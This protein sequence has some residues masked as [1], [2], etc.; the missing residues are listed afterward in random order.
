M[1]RAVERGRHRPEGTDIPRPDREDTGAGH[2]DEPNVVA[3]D[4]GGDGV[5]RAWLALSPPAEPFQ[6]P[7]DLIRAS[8]SP[9]GAG[10]RWT[11]NYWA[12]HPA[13]RA[14]KAALYR[15]L[16]PDGPRDLDLPTPT[17]PAEPWRAVLLDDDMADFSRFSFTP[18]LWRGVLYTELACSR[19]GVYPAE[20]LTIGPAALRVGS[21]E[22]WVH[23]GP[24][25]Y[26]HPTRSPLSLQLR[27][28]VNRVWLWGD[29]IG[30]REARLGL[31]LALPGPDA[32]DRLRVS[33][34]IGRHD[35]GTWREAERAL[36]AFRVPRFD[37]GPEP[38]YAV[39]APGAAPCSLELSVGVAG[40]G[41]P[42]AVTEE[43]KA[44]VEVVAGARF[45][46]PLGAAV[47]E[48]HARVAGETALEVRVR[49]AGGLPLERRVPFLAGGT[50]YRD[51]PYG[52]YDGRRLE[53][54]EHLAG[55]RGDVM[56]AVA[57]LL[58]DAEAGR[59][60]VVEASDLNESISFLEGRRDT[61]DFHALS[62]LVL[63]LRCD[64]LLA[65]T[66][67]DP[68]PAT[69]RERVSAAL[70]GFKYG[71]D[72]PGLD[73]MCYFTENH[74][75]LFHVAEHLAGARWPMARFQNDGAEGSVKA[76]RAG[77][78][79]ERW[80][81]HRLRSGFSEWDSNAY[82]AMDAF[83]LL[84]L[85]EYTEDASLG[86]LSVR[87]LDLLFLR[88][89]TQSFRGTHGSSHGRCYVAALRSGRADGTAGL[90]RIAFGMG[91]FNGETRATGMLALST[92]YRV[93]A[94]VRLLGSDVG[95]PS[96]TLA[97]SNGAY[98][99]ESDLRSDTWDVRTVTHRTPSGM[100]A[101]AVDQRPGA[102]GIQ[103]HLWQ[104]T[105]SPD[106]VVFTSQPGNRQGHGNARPNALAGSA[107]LPQVGMGERT[108]LCVY[109]DGVAPRDGG[110]LGV[111]D[112][113][114]SAMP[115]E[116]VGLGY[117]HAYFPT[118]S[119]D[120]YAIEGPW[121]FARHGA[122]YLALWS[123]GDLALT[124]D[125]PLAGAELRG[126]GCGR[127]WLCH[128]GSV[129]EDGAY[130]TFRERVLE[131]EPP[132]FEA[133]T[134]TLRWRTPQGERLELRWGQ[135]L[136]L[137][138]EPLRTQRFPYFGTDQGDASARA[139][140]GDEVLRLVAF[141]RRHDIRL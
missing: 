7:A 106:A 105:L 40:A 108:V 71:L 104:A 118:S 25:G 22:P 70:K 123:D 46:L 78:R 26:V 69:E 84:A 8:G 93:P 113:G 20:V 136:W 28:G 135:G 97:R 101:A 21:D 1:P 79:C 61:A 29:M 32:R 116:R 124:Q 59:A 77:Q 12:W 117:S 137:G 76:A 82:L 18:T 92:R 4:L 2:P 130:A 68:L 102:M 87:L 24:F 132:S 34:P 47:R 121:A 138:D 99:A 88:L 6:V 3:Y 63:L 81:R 128:V 44:T 111:L 103:E 139:E 66:G 5:V 83:A 91:T 74:Q 31:G 33:R 100:L 109:A 133:G 53:A 55:I 16:R 89:A 39:L 58:V 114:P 17:G 56:A 11:L 80:I 119:F 42:P 36:A 126:G 54:L 115:G 122:G 10:G 14:A 140:V 37:F 96:R 85:R 30:L 64:T 45:A 41:A 107:T 120:D 48:A 67:N 50:P 95:A 125:G 131:A 35:P 38:P 110:M 134:A 127:A 23:E 65:R 49:P 60:S 19:A 72:E 73:A 57:R 13:V 129:A 15:S 9:F 62:L 86:E 51:A 112:E 94:E 98:R 90:Q 52:T 43:D 27:E 141:G 75:L